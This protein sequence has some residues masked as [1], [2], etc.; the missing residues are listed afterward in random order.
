MNQ[1]TDQEI[2]DSLKNREN[3]VVSFIA[4]R[5]MPMVTYMIKENKAGFLEPEDLFQ[6][7][8]MIIIRKIDSD[9]LILKAKFSTYLYAVCKNLIE[10]HQKRKDV[11]QKYLISQEKDEVQ[12][13]DFSE[14]YDEDYENKIYQHYFSKLGSSC[15]EILRL[16][17]MDVPFKEIAK[18]TGNTESYVRKKKHDCKT[19]LIELV[20]N[21]PDNINSD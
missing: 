20:I 6:D 17:W 7:A 8:L 14:K 19:R 21:N 10:Y 11:R 16:F 3:H 13:E 2:V 9:E 18:K 4:K 5:Y 12:E 15:Q 1:Y